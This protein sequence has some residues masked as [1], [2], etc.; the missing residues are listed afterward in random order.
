MKGI[1]YKDDARAAGSRL[2]TLLVQMYLL[3]Y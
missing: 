3:Y 2:L 1:F